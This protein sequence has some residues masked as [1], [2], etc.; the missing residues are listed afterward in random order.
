M[1]LLEDFVTGDNQKLYVNS[2]QL[3]TWTHDMPGRTAF[4]MHILPRMSLGYSNLLL[5][6]WTNIWGFCAPE[7]PRLWAPKPRALNTSRQL[8][9]KLLY[10]PRLIECAIH[11]TLSV[12]I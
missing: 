11:Q 9:P 5:S 4:I 12:F 2:L 10:F 3:Q 8:V 6:R 1:K 7:N